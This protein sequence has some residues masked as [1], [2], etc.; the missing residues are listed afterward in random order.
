MNK[1]QDSHKEAI[2]KGIKQCE[3]AYNTGDAERLVAF[4]RPTK[5]P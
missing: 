4:Y 2:R 5:L 3:Q 1:S